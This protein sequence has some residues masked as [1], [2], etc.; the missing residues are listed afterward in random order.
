MKN[1]K[2]NGGTDWYYHYQGLAESTHGKYMHLSMISKTPNEHYRLSLM[3]A[4]IM[5]NDLLKN[6]DYQLVGKTR[7]DVIQAIKI[8]ESIIKR[9]VQ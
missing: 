6:A 7:E 2:I 8:S 5:C 1:S 4:L 3:Y 9:P